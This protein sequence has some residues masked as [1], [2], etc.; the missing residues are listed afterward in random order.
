MLKKWKCSLIYASLPCC[1]KL[2]L[3]VRFLSRPT[4]LAFSPSRRQISSSPLAS[5]RIFRLRVGICRILCLIVQRGSKT[6]VKETKLSAK[7][8]KDE[9][10][11]GGSRQETRVRVSCA[12]KGVE[13]AWDLEPE[14][15][16]PVPNRKVRPS[17]LI[18]G[19]GRGRGRG[20]SPF[21]PSRRFIGASF[22][23]SRIQEQMQER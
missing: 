23:P 13:F 6:V 4:D 19:R 18:L 12:A 17:R 14:R 3:F 1:W 10:E 5:T 20:V 21:E 16:L 7:K 11:F 9:D 15:S 2:G 8:R 22:F